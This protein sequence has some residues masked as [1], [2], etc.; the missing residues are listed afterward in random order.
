MVSVPFSWPSSGGVASWLTLA[1]AIVPVFSSV[2]TTSSV[3]VA[4][5][6]SSSITK[7]FSNSEGSGPLPPV[8]SSLGFG[9]LGF[10]A[11]DSVREL[12]FRAGEAE[13]GA[14]IF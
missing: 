8:P 14:A 9:R 13:A 1:S 4:S 2:L 11:G 3:L 10:V 6:G 5:S 7:A 12:G